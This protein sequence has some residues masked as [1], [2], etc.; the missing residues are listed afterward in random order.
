MLLLQHLSI[1]T[2]T[3]HLHTRTYVLREDSIRMYLYVRKL[4]FERIMRE[5]MIFP[6]QIFLM[7]QE[8]RVKKTAQRNTCSIILS[9]KYTTQQIPV[10]YKCTD[11]VVLICRTGYNM[12]TLQTTFVFRLLFIKK[13]YNVIRYNS[14]LSL[15]SKMSPCVCCVLPSVGSQV[16]KLRIKKMDLRRILKETKNR[17][18]EATTKA[19][20]KRNEEKK[21]A[22]GTWFNTRFQIRVHASNSLSIRLF[23][24]TVSSFSRR[25]DV[26]CFQVRRLPSP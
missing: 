20:G 3:I 26:I 25:V 7:K 15:P 22:A 23:F 10:W 6:V 4:I 14:S 13:K 5:L 19:K 21:K 18:C 2:Y 16:P 9:S 8:N 11:R 12:V 24:C 1:D 17:R